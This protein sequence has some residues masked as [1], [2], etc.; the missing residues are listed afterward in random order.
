MGDRV[1][2]AA[3]NIFVPSAWRFP[4]VTL[5]V[6]RTSRRLQDSWKTCDG[7]VDINITSFPVFYT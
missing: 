4:P 5:L 6:P 7:L 2:S 1:L 3:P